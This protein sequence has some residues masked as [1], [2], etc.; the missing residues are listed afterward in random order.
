MSFF[1][2]LFDF[3]FRATLFGAD[4]QY[5]TTYKMPA[6]TNRSDYIVSDNIGPFNLTGKTD[7]T[8]NYAYDPDLRNYAALVVNVSGLNVAA[9]TVSE[10]VEALNSNSGFSGLFLA[11]KQANGISIKT[12]RSRLYFRSYV[13]NSGAESVIKF[14]KNAPIFELPKYFERYSIENRFNYPDLGPSRLILLNPAD[15]ID[16]NIISN[17]GLDPLSP[18]PDWKLLKG[19]NDAFWFYKRTYT[20]GQLSSEIK[21]PAGAKEGDLAKKTHYI[22]NGSDLIEVMEVPYI[23]QSSDL[24]VPP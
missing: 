9:T 22:Y 13:S 15:P 11:S 12:K 17:A 16:S 8:I 24:L 14:N 5:Q 23:L 21:Y 3:E 10:V 2:N 1:Q 4:R 7:L 6:N 18:T 19:T 20:T